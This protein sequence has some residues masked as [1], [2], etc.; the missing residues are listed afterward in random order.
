ME[1]RILQLISSAEKNI[2]ARQYNAALE[3]LKAAEQIDPENKSIPMIT[4]IVKSLQSESASPKNIRQHLSVTIDPQSPTGV[5]ETTS[6]S[7][8]EEKKRVRNLTTS[9]EYFLSRGSVDNAFECL[10]RAY[11]LDPVASEVLTC[12]RQ[13]LPAWQKL[14]GKSAPQRSDWKLNLNVGAQSQPQ[15]PLFERLK[16][17]KI[18][19]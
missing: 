18:F 5:R 12:E 7:A 19:D 14:H 9:A 1:S 10:M 4:Q 2:E 8:D 13:I 6:S 3:Q 17:G 15:S 11:L 16:S